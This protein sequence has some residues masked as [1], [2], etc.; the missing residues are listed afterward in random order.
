[1]CVGVFVYFTLSSLHFVCPCL[2]LSVF[3]L[4]KI[5]NSALHRVKRQKNL[6]MHCLCRSTRLLSLELDLPQPAAPAP[7]AAFELD[8]DYS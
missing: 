8:S 1:M 6:S 7:A 2:S 5:S 3:P 4:C